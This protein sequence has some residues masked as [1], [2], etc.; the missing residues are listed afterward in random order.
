MIPNAIEMHKNLVENK[1]FLWFNISVD[2]HF[3]C[4]V[5]GLSFEI[6][7]FHNF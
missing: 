6:M 5:H 1:P 3:I 7:M 2:C 4:I